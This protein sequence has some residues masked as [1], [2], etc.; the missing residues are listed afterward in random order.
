MSRLNRRAAAI[1][2]GSSLAALFTAAAVADRD[3]RPEK[4]TFVDVTA[5]A[6]VRWAIARVASGGWNLVETMGGGGGFVDFDGDGLL[7]VYLVSYT[8]EP[9]AD[10][11]V[12]GDAL[13]RNNGDGTFTDVTS[14][15]G[16]G[17]SMRGMGL[18]AGDYDNDGWPDLY[19]SGF[20]SQRLY[21]NN[22][23]GTFADVTTVVGLPSE[24]GWGT[25]AAFLDHDGDGDL[26]LFVC[27]YLDVDPQRALPCQMIGDRP[28]C[29]IDRFRGSASALY[30]NDR[31]R[32]TEIGA[33]AGVARPDGKG[34][35]VVAADLD[36]DGRIDLF[37]ANDT[38]PNFLYR[39]R[40]DG[41]FSEVGLQAEVAF[42]PSGR[43]RGAMGVDVEDYDRDGR[44][45]LFVAN[46]THQGYSLF[47]NAGDGT[48]PDRARQ[49][50]LVEASLPMS[51][52]GARFLDEDNDGW[53]DLVVA[54]GHPFEPVAKVWPGIRY[55]EPAL[56][57]ENTSQRFREAVG[58]RGEA[59][60]RPMAG[61]GLATGDIDN[62]GDP[63]IL[64][65]GIGE[66]PRLLRNEGGN[67][68]HWLGVRLEGTRSNRDGVG[69]VVRV[70]VGGTQRIK[71]RAGGT[72]YASVSDPRLL[73]GLGQAARVDRLEVRWPSGLVT[74]LG[75]VAVD[76]YLTVR[77]G[78]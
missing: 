19:V 74:V 8:L 66:P 72:S 40:G 77:E 43:A 69:A 41:T 36:G 21:R 20:R 30:R 55:A 51:G 14:R 13:Y 52:F 61:R 47:H 58:Q 11:H 9:Q 22:R 49:M 34:L 3:G 33:A 4:P 60:A 18:A 1:L 70:T 6:G 48:L 73:F 17:G 56:L 75:A 68:N 44:L 5:A 7:D 24:S 32:F 15:A 53:V 63:D 12:P 46:F 76:R 65:L 27:R 10:G 31:G 2:A 42:D 59:L 45:D 57:F 16:L 39:N 64:L 23:D 71:V 54:N 38:S 29:S 26:D 62:D 35:G 78:E 25:S 50:G 28:F 67:R 37:Q